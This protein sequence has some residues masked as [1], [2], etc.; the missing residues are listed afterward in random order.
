MSGD[1]FLNTYARYPVE[2]VEGRG[3]RVKDAAGRWYLDG[4]AGIAVMALGHGHP[5]VLAAVH[6]QVDRLMHVSNLYHVPIQRTFAGKLSAAFGGSKVFLGNSGTEAN[7]GAVK[8]CRKWHWR[9]G[10]PR[11]E[12]LVLESAF[13]GRTM[14]A[15]AM[16]PRPAY[17]EGYGPFPPGVRVVAPGDLPGA[18]SE[19]TACVFVEPVQGEGGCRPIENLAEIRAACEAHDALLVYDEIQ[20]GLGRTGVFTHAPHADVVTVAK[21]LGGGLPLS[22]IVAREKVSEVFKPGDHGSTFGGNPVACAAGAA[23][24]DVILGEDLPASCAAMGARLRAGLEASGAR[25]T[26]RG[27]LLAAHIEGPAAPV[28]GRMMEQG[29]LVC[30]AGANAVRFVPPY[31]ITE[32]EVDE[33]VGVFAGSL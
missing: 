25:V 26:G 17:Q 5:A 14:M 27:L 33:L 29:A 32:G 18:I 30:S 20:S 28:I 21:A 1:P 9:R 7:E 23:T 8:L 31:V 16:T 19:R 15:L 2:L 4:C 12:V 11:E 10:Q 3:C 13:H 24:L 22:A 6:A